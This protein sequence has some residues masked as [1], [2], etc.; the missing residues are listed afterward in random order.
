MNIFKIN[1]LEYYQNFVSE[2]DVQLMIPS[3][4]TDQIKVWCPNNGSHKKG[5]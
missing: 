2:V 1:P 4:I 5:S 3:S